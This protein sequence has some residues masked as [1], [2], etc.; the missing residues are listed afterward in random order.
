MPQEEEKANNT[1]LE[2]KKGDAVYVED[3]DSERQYETAE[4]EPKLNL[5]TVLAY[6]ALASQFNAY[7]L[8]LLMPSTILPYINADLGPNPNYTWITISW[9]LCASIIVSVGGRLADIFW[10][11]LFYACWSYY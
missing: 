3:V 6:L 8:T 2:Q 5:Q 10:P 7:I 4:L 9:T 11:P 1:E